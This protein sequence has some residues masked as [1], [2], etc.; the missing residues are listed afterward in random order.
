MYGVDRLSDKSTFLR[1]PEVIN[2]FEYPR[3][4]SSPITILQTRALHYMYMF[5]TR[6]P[7]TGENK[8]LDYSYMQR[9]DFDYR[10][11]K[12]SEPTCCAEPSI[13]HT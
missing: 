2:V 12:R 1:L 10:Y 8:R 4:A 5:H 11:S 3:V 9:H 7:D 6:L 13:I